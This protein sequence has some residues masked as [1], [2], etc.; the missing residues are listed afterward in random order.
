[1]NSY[2]S[3]SF[4]KYFEGYSETKVPK[5]NG[6][7]YKIVRT[8]TGIY[9]Q[10]NLNDFRW[11]LLKISYGILF[12]LAALLWAVS[13]MS[14]IDSN[15]ESYVAVMV[16]LSAMAFLW[17]FYKMIFYL[18]SKRNLTAGSYHD[19]I[20]IQRPSILAGIGMLLTTLMKVIFLANHPA[21]FSM[22]EVYSI[23]EALA[24]SACCISIY[25]I[26]KTM[27]YIHKKNPNK[28]EGEGV[29]IER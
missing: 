22:K 24:S 5:Q 8:Y 29:E 26:E 18:A 19:C 10:H 17:L 14:R 21:S 7:G 2:H 1:M 23:L 28:T 25:K 12:A 16:A 27:V 3:S 9:Y 4:H 6:K 11:I 20:E 15:M 13:G